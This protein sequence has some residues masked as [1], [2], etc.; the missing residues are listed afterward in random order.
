[1]Q[2]IRAEDAHAIAELELTLFR[3]NCL[4]WKTIESE[5]QHGEGFVIYNGGRLIAYL[6]ARTSVG[7]TDILRLGVLSSEQGRGYGTSLI[8]A[9]LQI[10][11]P[12]NEIMLTVRKNN[13]QAIRLYRR[14][15]FVIV[16]QLHDSWVMLHRHGAVVIPAR[17]TV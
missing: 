17:A 1:M 5:I 16:G 12:R 9:L 11:H 13:D 4:N 10:R 2:S 7:I 15:G 3:D 6:L 8:Q 14:H